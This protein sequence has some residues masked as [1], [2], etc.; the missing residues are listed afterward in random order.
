MK[1]LNSP[2]G[3]ILILLLLV[4]IGLVSDRM[5]V[6]YAKDIVTATLTFQLC[7]WFW[8]DDGKEADGRICSLPTRRP[9]R[10][11]GRW[12]KTGRASVTKRSVTGSPFP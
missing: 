9:S 5:G 2:G 4:V 12:A 1:G 11:D 7:W 3:R 8:L 10:R 6:P